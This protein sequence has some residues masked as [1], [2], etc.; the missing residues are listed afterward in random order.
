MLPE[1]E[2]EIGKSNEFNTSSKA[3]GSSQSSFIYS[4]TDGNVFSS[5]LRLIPEEAL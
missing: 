5:E 1:I 4:S 2:I 3:K